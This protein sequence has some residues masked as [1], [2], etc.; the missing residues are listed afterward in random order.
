MDKIITTQGTIEALNDEQKTAIDDITHF[1]K[2]GDPS[3]WFVLEGKAGTGKTTIMTKVLE[4]FLGKR[5]VEICALSHKAKKVLWDKLTGGLLDLPAGLNSHSVAGLLGMTLNMETGKFTK[6]YS[7]KKP[8][9]R[10]ADIIVVDEGS[11]INEEALIHIMDS[12]KPKAKVI[13]VGDI[14]QLPPIREEHDPASGTPSPVFLSENKVKLTTRVRQDKDS[15]ILPYSDFYWENSVLKD[16]EEEDP[17]P[18]TSRQTGQH[19]E[20]SKD[21]EKVL[22]DNKDLFLDGIKTRNP[23]LIKTI[24]YRNKT[25][26]SVNWFIRKLIFNNPNEFE[27]GDQLIFNDNYFRGDKTVF[28][29]SSEVT[30][31]DVKK[32]EFDGKYHGH[33]LRVTDGE[34][35]KSIETISEVSVP[36]WNKHV[37]ELF[38][39]AKRIPHGVKR[40]RALRTAWNAR[41]RFANIDYAYTLTSHKAQ[42]STYNTVIVV[43][44]DIL[45]VS[46]IENVEKS[47]SMYVAITRASDK[48][49][50]VSELN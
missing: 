18:L 40:N 5:R 39:I 16:G 27:V 3:Q 31:L 35:E 50:I 23:D 29:N 48:V 15:M 42:G 6:A 21:L 44:D 20:F 47:Q 33:I 4:P 49:Y 32:R 43:E 36:S 24:V 12:K 13:F 34:I 45:E 25:K 2:K 41:N 17:V 11:M 14:G 26:K 10:W 30:V 9:I 28:E 1:I 22:T 7:K 8:P 37:S 46:M 19:I 38:N